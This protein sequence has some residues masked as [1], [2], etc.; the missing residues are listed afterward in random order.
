[1]RHLRITCQKTSSYCGQHLTIE[2]YYVFKIFLK[3]ISFLWDHW[4][5]CFGLL[6]MFAMGFTC[7]LHLL[8]WIPQIHLW[9]DTC[10]PLGSQHGRQTFSTH[11]LANIPTSIGGVRT[12]ERGCR[13]TTLLTIRYFKVSWD[14]RVLWCLWVLC[15][16]FVYKVSQQ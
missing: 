7:M 14:L 12:H 8:Q 6:E 16:V 13:N 4:Y 10:W 15:I 1:M 2:C 11:I 5:P 3:N 9:C